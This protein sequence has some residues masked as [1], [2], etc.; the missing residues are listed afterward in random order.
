MLF[1]GGAEAPDISG[2]W[3]GDDWGQVELEEVQPGEYEGT[4]TDTYEQEPGTIELKWDKGE[5]RYI[6]T[7]AE[8]KSRFGKISVRLVDGEIRGA[9][10]AHKKSRSRFHERWGRLRVWRFR[11]M[12]NTWPAADSRLLMRLSR[13]KVHAGLAAQSLAPGV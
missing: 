7:W 12:E 1:A 9:W 13:F 10:T 4:H 3:H 6:G 11:P 5:R 2:L 8:K